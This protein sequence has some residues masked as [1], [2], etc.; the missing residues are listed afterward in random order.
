MLDDELRAFQSEREELLEQ[1]EGQFV[2]YT[3]E[4]R[5]GVFDS[6]VAAATAAAGHGRKDVLVREIRREEPVYFVPSVIR[7][8]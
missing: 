3:G 2:A 4:K 8:E 7:V 5:I 6:Y 1:H